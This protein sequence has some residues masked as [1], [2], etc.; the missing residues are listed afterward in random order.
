MD[1]ASGRAV[2]VRETRL[3]PR[4]ARPD[5][6]GLRAV[7]RPHRPAGQPRRGRAARPARH[8]PQLGLRAAAAA[9]RRGR[10][11]ATPS[12]A[13][14]SS[15]SPTARSSACSSTTSRSTCA[16]ATLES[17]ERD[18]RPAGRHAASGGSSGARPRATRSG[19]ASTRLVSLTQRAVAAISYEVEPSTARCG[20]SC[21]RS[22]SPTRSCPTRASDPRTAAVLEHAARGRGA[23]RV[24]HRGAAGA[25]HPAERPARGGRHGPRDR[26]PREHR[27]RHRELR[28]R[29]PAHHRHPRSSPA[30]SCGSSSTSPTAGRASAP[31]RRCTTRWRRRWPP[32]ASTG[33]DGL[34]ARAARL[35]RRLL[36][37]RRRR[38]RGRRRDAAGRALRAVPH[39]PGRRPGR[40]AAD[41]GKG[42]T[43]PGY[44]GHAFWDT[45]T[46]VLPVLTYTKPERRGR[47]AA[48]A[49]AARC[50]SPRSGP[51]AGPRGRGVPVADD[52]R[53]ASA[54]A[55]GRPAPRR[56][57]STPTSPTPSCATSTPP[58]TTQFERE[59]G[60]RPAR[61]DRPAVAQPRPPRPAGRFRID[62]VTGPDEYSAIV[63]NN[64]YTNLMAQQNLR[65][66]ADVAPGTATG[67]HELGVDDR[68]DGRRGATPP[69]PWSS[70][71]T[72]A[73]RAPAERGLHRPRP[74]G[75]RRHT[76][77]DNYPLLLH[78]P[79]FDLYR[80][81]VVKQADL[82]LAMHLR[83]A[84]RSRPRR[85]TAT[86]ATTR[87]S[88][89]AT[90]RCRRAPRR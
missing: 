83:A 11:T 90:R 86:S 3:R 65:A 57:T 70:P 7:Q 67:P 85:R 16:T 2:G 4:R 25:P 24:G 81:Q 34:L 66:A 75:L 38:A 12:R 9:V 84:T 64:V 20:S 15:T 26:R 13:R 36:G 35:P 55:T 59:V 5:R 28:R 44:D 80:K 39:P 27:P 73:R 31:A 51:R 88:P 33:W 30:R 1:A 40:A 43:G 87:R 77:P 10:A 23:H 42:L 17:H 74:V 50:R 58:R 52:P 45:E 71:T 6:V 37:R 79:Y 89:C 49:A 48:L 8:L 82:V 18:A 22:S 53:P 41:P 14:R 46:F 72:S 68:G 32:P 60:A 56:S 63:D 29:L 78:Y 69:T 19:S 61:R 21:S 62:G 76:G 54:P 47:R